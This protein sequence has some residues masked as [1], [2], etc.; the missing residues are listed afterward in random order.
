M[1]I[2]RTL[3]QLSVLVFTVALVYFAFVYYP[4]VLDKYKNQ[5][6]PGAKPVVAPVSAG[7]KKFPVETKNFRIEYSEDSDTYYV[8][9]TGDKLDQFLINRNS[10]ALTLKNTLS[11]DSLCSYKVIYSGQGGL[12]VPDQYKADPGCSR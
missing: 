2:F 11:V 6:V 7:E 4:K 9:V 1:K 8:F 5:G 12:R 3:T 10:A